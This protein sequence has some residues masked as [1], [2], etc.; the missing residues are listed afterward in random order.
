M[1][2]KLRR[3]LEKHVEADIIKA[4]DNMGFA[5]TKTSQPRPSMLTL[6]IPD[7]YAAH[8]VWGIRCW[9]EVKRPGGKT[10]AHQE[11]WHAAERAAGGTVFVADG[12]RSL[13]HELKALGAP[14]RTL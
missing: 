14:V 2:T 4:L 10:S 12:V 7:L 13:L 8:P 5:V 9:I 1:T 6:G 11:A 3:P